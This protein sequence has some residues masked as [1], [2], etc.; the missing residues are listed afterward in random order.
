MTCT[1][2][3]PQSTPPRYKVAAIT[4]L[5][6]YP[7]VLGLSMLLARLDLGLPLALSNL[8]V[9]LGTVLLATYAA[10]P[11]LSWLLRGWLVPGRDRKSGRA[12]RC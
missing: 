12:S 6:I 4:W 7:L 8:L 1:E 3:R 2:S 11:A 10:V 5:A 9:T